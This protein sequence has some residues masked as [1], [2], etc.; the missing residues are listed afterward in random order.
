M[1]MRT[2]HRF[3]HIEND[4]ILATEETSVRYSIFIITIGGSQGSL[5]IEKI[6]I[7]IHMG[8]SNRGPNK[9]IWAWQ[10]QRP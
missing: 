3:L 10:F 8:M 5:N 9:Q 7:Y 2:L 1:Y 4:L 6:V